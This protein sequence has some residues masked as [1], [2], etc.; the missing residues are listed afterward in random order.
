M[1]VYEIRHVSADLV[2]RKLEELNLIGLGTGTPLKITTSET[3]EQPQNARASN[4]GTAEVLMQKPEVVVNETT[5]ALFIKA[6]AEQHEQIAKIIEYIDSEM[7]EEELSYEIYPLENSSPDHVAGLLERLVQETV[8]SEGKVENPVKRQEKITI[9]PDPNTFSLIV[10][11]SKKNQQWIGDLTKSLDKR[12]PQ[13]LIDVTLVEITRT[14]TF[15]YDL[16]LVANA[17]DA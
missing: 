11:A 10:H 1:H 7:P 15:E 2:K 5:N 3:S 12:R 14:D 16:N 8:N 6:T 13:V 4:T 17:K 9:V